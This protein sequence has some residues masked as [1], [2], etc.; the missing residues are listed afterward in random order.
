MARLPNCKHY[1]D[2]IQDGSHYERA[3]S[4]HNSDLESKMVEI[5]KFLN[6]G[7]SKFAPVMVCKYSSVRTVRYFTIELGKLDKILL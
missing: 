6:A 4:K 1:T 2:S 3:Q 7:N 5:T